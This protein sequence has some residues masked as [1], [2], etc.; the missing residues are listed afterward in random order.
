MALTNANYFTTGAQYPPQQHVSRHSDFQRYQ[1]LYEGSQRA[2]ALL[3]PNTV[4][5][6]QREAGFAS[7]D[8]VT[9]AIPHIRHNM[10]RKL[11]RFWGSMLYSFPP[12]ID[13]NLEDANR[14]AN[15]TRA[16]Y[17]IGTKVAVDCSRYGTGVFYISNTGR[18]DIVRSISP[19]HWFPVVS[20]NDHDIILGDIIAVPYASNPQ[21]EDAIPDRLRVTRLIIGEPA[22]VE[23]FVLN[24]PAGALG[25]RRSFEE[26][27]EVTQRA[28]A[29]VINGY[30]DDNHYGESDYPDLITL[31]A[32]ID[33]RIAGNSQVMT[34]HS[35]PH[36]YG[37]K[38]AIS[39]DANGN[40][41]IN[42][43]GQYFPI[44][45]D[46]KPPAYLVWDANLEANFNQIQHCLNSF[47]ILSDTS[48]AAFGIQG[49]GNSV[50]SGAALRKLL[51]TSFL[52]LGSLR[53][54]HEKAIRHIFS[55]LIPRANPTITW[56]EPYLDGLVDGANA[57][58]TRIQSGTTTAVQ[59][60]QRLDHISER[61]ARQIANA[62]QP[63]PNN[64]PREDNSA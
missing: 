38:S 61:E 7:V 5:N 10:F 27:S 25:A 21:R 9:R 47:H 53:R 57:E 56:V 36:M 60:I 26:G 51:Y 44:D 33:E 3:Y 58:A 12:I 39:Y 35:N 34:R 32:E 14:V 40:A 31:V 54:M 20:A 18:D 28:I 22:T 43:S 63:A 17:D 24:G 11:S 19:L 16:I 59:A 52:R 6:I 41:Q 45:E 23:V 4:R 50:E 29:T 37:P 1:D 48:A 8:S 15:V 64:D 30:E 13:S 49:D 42:I 55:I 46:D 2:F 62:A